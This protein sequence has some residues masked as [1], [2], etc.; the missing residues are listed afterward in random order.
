MTEFLRIDQDGLTAGVAGL[1]RTDGLATG[2]LVTLTDTSSTGTTL[3]QLLWTPPGDAGAV[4]SLAAT[5][6]PK[7]WTFEPTAGKY[8]SYLVELVRNAGLTSAT[9]ERRVL[10]MRTPNLGL[11]IPALNER[12]Y[13]AASLVDSRGAELVDN[14][15]TDFADA[16]LNAVPFAAWWRAMHELILAVDANDGGGGEPPAV[17]VTHYSG[18]ES[19]RQSYASLAAALAAGYPNS[20]PSVAV[21]DIAPNRH[22]ALGDPV[23]LDNTVT[24]VLR[25]AVGPGAAALAAVALPALST[26]D[27]LIIEGCVAA[28]AITGEGTIRLRRA[29]VSA[30]VVCSTL[31]AVDSRFDESVAVELGANATFDRCA[32]GSSVAFTSPF[33]VNF[34]FQ[35]CSFGESPTVVFTGG[36]GTVTMDA[37]SNVAWLDAGGAVTNGTIV[38]ED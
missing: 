10:V 8:G 37:R 28:G 13:S 18:V 6:D 1:S 25:S 15:A 29:Q 22:E 5:G 34:R 38:V 4:S 27:E 24:Y 2:A 20:F 9:R 26:V 17:L 11:V 14:N 7:V 36:P 19:A 3:M 23:V 35:N 31:E 12:G 21:Y 16:D 33:E 30:G 32:I